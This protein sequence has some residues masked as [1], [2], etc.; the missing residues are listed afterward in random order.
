LFVC[1][2]FFLSLNV[3]ENHCQDLDFILCGKGGFNGAFPL[4][5]PKCPDSFTLNKLECSRQAFLL[6]SGQ[7]GACIF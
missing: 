3:L 5:V 6:V 4:L 1:L 7:T 2:F